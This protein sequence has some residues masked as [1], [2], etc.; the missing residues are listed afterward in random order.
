[1]LASLKKFIKNQDE[2]GHKMKVN[3]NGEETFTTWVGALLSISY[4]ILIVIIALFGA[5]EVMKYQDP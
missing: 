2:F 3:Y 4:L 5:V 1:M